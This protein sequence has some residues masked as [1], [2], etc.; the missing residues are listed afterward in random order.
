MVSRKF[1]PVLLAG[2]LLFASPSYAQNPSVTTGSS[3]SSSSSSLNNE[4]DILSDAV[5]DPNVFTRMKQKA[6]M[7]AQR[8]NYVNQSL[9]LKPDSIFALTCYDKQLGR[10]MKNLGVKEKDENS[11]PT[12]FQQSVQKIGAVSNAFVGTLGKDG[13]P[14]LTPSKNSNTEVTASDYESTPQTA[15]SDDFKCETMEKLWQQSQCGN[16]AA[17][18][19]PTLRE[20]GSTNDTR[21]YPAACTA[22]KDDPN[23][24][25][26]S[27]AN[28]LTGIYAGGNKTLP[29]YN[30]T[31]LYLCQRAPFSELA[32]LKDE[33]GNELCKVQS[34]Q[35]DLCWPGKKLGYKTPLGPEAVSCS[36]DGCTPQGE[37]GDA[38]MKCKKAE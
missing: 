3:N 24:S 12:R 38:V 34:G 27:Y 35:E 9:I 25:T 21:K 11:E 15:S 32:D 2:C 36:N 26:Y 4:S 33:D 16:F 8:E 30:N 31:N 10:T 14:L 37:A 1:F 22:G 5:C 7:E 28:G 29:N 23:N 17:G 6:R 19:L 13:K 18:D 20:A